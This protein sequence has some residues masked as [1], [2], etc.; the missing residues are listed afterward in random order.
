ME[1][2]RPSVRGTGTRKGQKIRMRRGHNGLGRK[3]GNRWNRDVG[4]ENRARICGPFKEPR[5]R[6]P[7][8]RTGTTTLYVVP[9][10]QAT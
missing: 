4:T 3:K 2:N 9:A 1:K 6:F 8:W 10:R 5:N 7:A